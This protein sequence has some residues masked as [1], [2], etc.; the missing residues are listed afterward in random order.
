MAGEGGRVTGEGLSG[1]GGGASELFVLRA[2][3]ADSCD[4]FGANTGVVTAVATRT[5]L[6]KDGVVVGR[7]LRVD[8]GVEV[9]AES[10][11]SS[12]SVGSGG[13]EVLVEAVEETKAVLVVGPALL[14][15]TSLALTANARSIITSS[16][17]AAGSASDT[18]SVSAGLELHNTLGVDGGR[19]ITLN[20]GSSLV[21][22]RVD[23]EIG[24]ALGR[25]GREGTVTVDNGAGESTV[26]G[27]SGNETGEGDEG[28]DG[29]GGTHVD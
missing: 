1:G 24:G 4:M 13:G 29:D 5:V 15:E 20:S 28:S 23:E 26:G 16:V 11:E 22:T 18:A 12:A 6:V 8:G 25:I 3:S 21:G 7:F 19:T 9:L 2:V 27:L 10:T 17:V 14:S